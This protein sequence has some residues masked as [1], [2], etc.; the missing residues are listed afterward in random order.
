MAITNASRLADFGTGIG[1]AGAVIDIDNA[2][3]QVGLGTTNPNSTVTVGSVGASG[4][5]LFVHG[6][7][8]VTG[9]LTAGNFSGNLTGA[10]TSSGAL[11]VT[12]TTSST[13]TTTGAL[14]VSG[15]IGVAKSIFVGEGISVA[16]TITYNDV[17]NIDSI[18]FV[19]AGKGLRATTGGLIVSAGVATIGAKLSVA[20]ITS[21]GDVVSSGIITA[22]SYYGSGANLTNIDTGVAGVNTTGFS[23]FK[24]VKHAGITT[25]VGIVSCSDVISTG[26][27]TAKAFVPTAGQ[28]SNR[29]LVINGSFIVA[30]R[31]ASSTSGGYQCVDRWQLNDNNTNVTITQ[32]QHA[33]TSGD[34]GPWALGFRKSYS[35]ALSAAGNS[36]GND[37]YI[38]LKY[39]M[40]AQDVALSGWDYTNTARDITLSFWFK[41]STNQTF[42][43]KL[44]SGDGTNK[45]YSFGFTATGN[46]TWTKITK[47]IPG[48][49][50]LQFD[51]NSDY[52]LGLYFALYY[53]TDSTGSISLDTWRNQD[54]N[55]QYPNMA[56]TWITAGASTFEITG[57]QIEVGSVATPFEHRCYQDEL[58][59]CQRYFWGWINPTTKIGFANAMQRTSDMF[60]CNLRH[61]VL[62]RTS[63]TLATSTDTGDFSAIWV[64]SGGDINSSGITTPG[65]TYDRTFTY[66]IAGTLDSGSYGSAAIGV[67]I[68][69]DGSLTFSAEL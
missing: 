66:P 49:A 45:D 8:R 54:N 6:D 51:L 17:T 35:A 1:T 32:S 16:G 20:G 39:V 18:G 42:Y 5:S 47:V 12:D 46:D 52:G 15:G 21:L 64:N 28:L 58:L 27:I 44:N 57:V 13:S 30:Q 23:T 29:N 10:V 37:S 38:R 55:T 31:G 25:C 50:D 65:G 2:H 69:N 26:I 14:K 59:R 19:T 7:G 40:E 3:A 53:G 60:M 33:L 68:E 63:P 41:C 67:T 9:V 61:P 62:M 24:D 48:H 34:S 4:T 36:L 11:S 43:G 22:D 56:D